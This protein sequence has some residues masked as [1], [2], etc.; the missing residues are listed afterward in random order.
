MKIIKSI[1][2]AVAIAASMTISANAQDLKFAH[3]DSQKFLSELPEWTAAQTALQEEAKKLSD[4]M[5][6]M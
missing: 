4:Q 6:V 2:A 1:L 5:S 3:I